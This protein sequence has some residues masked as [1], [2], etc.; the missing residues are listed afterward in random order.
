MGMLREI[1]ESP[2]TAIFMGVILAGIAV[3]GKLS[4][5][6]AQVFF[7]VAFVVACLGLRSLPIPTA[8]GFGLLILGGLILLA[9]WAKPD[10][11]PGYS[12]VLTSKSPMRVETLFSPASK[13]QTRQLE[14]GDSGTIFVAL[15]PEMMPFFNI[16]GKY[17]LGRVVN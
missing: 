8:V 13:I 3:S 15:G 9:Y 2:L 1:V 14:V 11:V 4:V 17:E 16:F 5:T 6:A 10:I 12:G 7:G